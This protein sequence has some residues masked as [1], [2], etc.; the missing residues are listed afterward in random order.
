MTNKTTTKVAKRLN[1]DALTD[2]I[3]SPSLSQ[4]E[5]VGVAGGHDPSYEN[6]IRTFENNFMRNFLNNFNE[7]FWDNFY[8]NFYFGS[9]GT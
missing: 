3:L 1:M 9:G 8:R 2:Q 7:N 5:L 6:F 4:S